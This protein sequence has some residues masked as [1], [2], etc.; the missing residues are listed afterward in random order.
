MKPYN[1][2]RDLDKN[3]FNNDDGTEDCHE[4]Y[5]E[6]DFVSDENDAYFSAYVE[7]FVVPS[8][9]RGNGVG[10]DLFEK[11]ESELPPTVKYLSLIAADLGSG[12][13]R[14]FWSARG[15]VP[16]FDYTSAPE[17]ERDG[18]KTIM[19]KGVNGTPNPAAL[20]IDQYED[21]PLWVTP[22]TFPEATRPNRP[23][24]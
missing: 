1:D 18:M 15:F 3:R 5:F 24:P 7:M 9:M 16:A 14:D 22:S 17:D 4:P 19:V 13:T 8:S 23:K 21:E 12:N 2:H 6:L 10:T 20:P 11:L